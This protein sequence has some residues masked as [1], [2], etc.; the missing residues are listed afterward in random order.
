[1]TTAQKS[2]LLL[3]DDSPTSLKV[4][5]KYFNQ[6][7]YEIFAAKSGEKAL[8]VLTQIKPDI[9][10]LDVMMP[11]IDGF[12]TCHRIKE[13]EE[14]REIPIIFMTALSD[15]KNK[16]KGFELGAVD[17]L[18][19]PLQKEEVLARVNTHLMIHNQHKKLASQKEELRELNASKDRLLLNIFPSK[20]VEDLKKSGKTEPQNFE[21]VSVLFSDFVGFT[22][23][24]SSLD[25][26]VVIEELS[27]IFTHFDEIMDKNNCER[28]KTIGDAYLAV[29]GMPNP[30]QNHAK[31]VI[32]A[33][34]EIIDYLN[35]R[36]QTTEI[37]WQPR[38]GVHSGKVVG[39]IVGIKKYIYDVFGDTINTA[40]RMESY[41]ESMKINVSDATY[42]LVKD[43]FEFFER[44]TLFVKGKG[45]MKMYFVNE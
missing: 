42:Q 20:I 17:Y 35:V 1:M 7:D 28:I 32:N 43:E 4:L 45:R 33:A 37:K 15:T 34:L 39:G 9:I 29:S 21:K 30:N 6:F 25:P 31:S 18:T 26:K 44:E 3:V 23:I 8:E 16:V 14:M 12:E 27:D 41:S 13:N 2:T 11:G 10:L 22:E 24:S 36:N 5:Y 40:S 38:I 19:K